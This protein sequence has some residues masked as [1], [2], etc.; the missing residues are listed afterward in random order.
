MLDPVDQVA[1]VRAPLLE[2]DARVEILGVLAD[3]DEVD[4]FVS[5]ADAGVALAGPDLSVEVECLAQR[6]VHRAEACA[7]G[8]R[9]RP[10]ERDAVSLDRVEGVVRQGIAAELLHDIGA[11]LLDVPLELGAARLEHAPGRLGELRARP[12]AGDQGDAMGHLPW[13]LARLGANGSG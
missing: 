12:V 2:F 10:L 6:H 13:T 4:L 3:D 5:R 7:Y 1:R 11:G 8:S 9:D